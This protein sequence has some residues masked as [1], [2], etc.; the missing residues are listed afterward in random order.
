[1]NDSQEPFADRTK[2]RALEVLLG[3]LAA[4]R[5]TIKNPAATELLTD[6]LA[7]DILETAWKHQFDDD[8]RECRNTIQEIVGIAIEDR[9]VESTDAATQP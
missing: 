6:A 4:L 8:R 2:S 9:E 1:M 3:R 7:K 5:P